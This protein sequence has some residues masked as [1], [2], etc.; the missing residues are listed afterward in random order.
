M[1]GE[2]NRFPV[3]QPVNPGSSPHA[4]GAYDA[5]RGDRDR[6]GLIP[7]CAGSMRRSRTRFRPCWAHPRMRGEHAR[8]GAAGAR[9]PGLIPAC[10]GSMSSRTTPDR[11]KGAHPR[12]RGEHTERRSA[13]QKR[14]GSSPHARGASEELRRVQGVGGL[15]PAC[16]GSASPRWWW[17][18]W[19]AHPRMRG[20]RVVMFGG[21]PRQAGSSPHARGAPDQRDQHQPDRGLIPAC[22][23]SADVANHFDTQFGAHPR[24]RGERSGISA[25]VRSRG[26][27]SPHARGARLA[28]R[29]LRS[30]GG[31]IPACA[32]SALPDLHVLSPPPQFSFTFTQLTRRNPPPDTSHLRRPA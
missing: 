26:G 28:G 20:E 16:A 2:H 19:R 22:A 15:I 7:A 3:A 23:G 17:W 9:R 12:M 24:M 27:S 29:I 13:R 25:A 10:A 8:P 30:V 14:K 32:G 1:R 11:S 6:V 31:L 4:R 18:V 21:L 5:P